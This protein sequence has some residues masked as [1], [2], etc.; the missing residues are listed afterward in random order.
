MAAGAGGG[1]IASVVF[2]SVIA[3]AGASPALVRVL[4]SGW[5]AGATGGADD[6]PGTGSGRF[7]SATITGSASFLMS[8][9][10]IV[11]EAPNSR[12]WPPAGSCGSGDPRYRWY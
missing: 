12:P 4:V 5:R 9:G 3:A 11:W 2:L 1:A 10:L 8:S 6:K 7:K